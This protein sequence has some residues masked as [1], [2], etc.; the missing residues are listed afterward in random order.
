[1]YADIL[2][3][4]AT[5]TLG[6][7]APPSLEREARFG[8][9]WLRQAWDPGQGVIYFQVGIGSGNQDGTFNGDHDLWRLPEKD[10]A[11]TGAA[12]RYLRVRPAF[13]ST[14]PAQ[15]LPPTLAGRMAAAFA[16][17]AQLDA[18]HHPLR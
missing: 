8:L 14:A 9:R 17:A 16:L 4:A 3:M 11:L 1:A 5:R 18:H 6:P 12:N 7:D 13:R 2:L 10:D 15:P